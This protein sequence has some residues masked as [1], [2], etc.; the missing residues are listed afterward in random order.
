M[1]EKVLVIYKAICVAS[2]RLDYFDILYLKLNVKTL[3]CS[4]RNK[5][6]QSPI[7]INNIILNRE[8]L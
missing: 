6:I 2:S 1:L 7:S 4:F 3:Y 8:Q 5:D